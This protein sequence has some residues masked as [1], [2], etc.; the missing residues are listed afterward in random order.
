MRQIGLCLAQF[1]AEYGSYP[2]DLTITQVLERHPENKISLGTSS[3]N[4]Y[5]HQ[6]FASG[7]V[8]D[9]SRFYGYGISK[10]R[11]T[12]VVDAKLPLPPGTCGFAYIIT[13]EVLTPP[14]TPIAVYPLQRGKY[15]CEKKL[16]KKW[17]NRAAVL[18]T[19]SSVRT[20]PIDS[21]GRIMINGLD[22]F[23]PAQAHWHGR[24]FQVKWPE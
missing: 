17:G 10:R 5:F 8:D 22:L 15:I 16:T 19:D 11:E 12:D 2:N 14:F 21:S 4:D 7:I 13:D 3:S 20:Y 23:D 18:F 24:S 1:E 9:T 6:F